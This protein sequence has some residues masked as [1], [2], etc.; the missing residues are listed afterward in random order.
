[1]TGTQESAAVAVPDRFDPGK[2]Q[3]ALEIN[4]ATSV[5][6]YAATGGEVGGL[7]AF[8][9]ELLYP[10]FNALGRVALALTD[11]INAQNQLGAA[12]AP[13]WTV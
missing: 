13:T 8:R 7:L 11:D 2:L 12:P 6:S 9:D 1:M 10:A 4:G 5:V 3:L